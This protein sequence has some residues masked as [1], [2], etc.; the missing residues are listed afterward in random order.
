MQLYRYSYSVQS[1]TTKNDVETT[2][3]RARAFGHFHT[4]WEALLCKL[5][6]VIIAYSKR[7][8]RKER[9]KKTEVEER[10]IKLDKLVS[11]GKAKTADLQKLKLLND[12][13]IEAR[14]EKLKGA[15][16]RSRA[17]WLELGEKPSKYFLNLENR[18]RINK[19]IN[20]IKTDDNKIIQ[21]GPDGYTPEFYQKNWPELGHYFLSYVN[22]SKYRGY[23]T[24]SFLDGVI[25]CLPKTG[26]SRN[27]IKNWRPISLL[28]T[29]YKLFSTCITNRLRPL[30]ENIV[31]SE[32]KGFLEN[33]SINDCTRLMFDVINGCNEKEIDGLILLVDFEKA[34]D[35]IS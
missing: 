5:R 17:E 35:S 24:P 28:N 33:R 19:M 9:V 29:S 22:E 2:N 10:I 27:L 30:L 26:K 20:K 31:S 1:T 3:R 15:L 32:Q 4:F 16:I 11:T 14:Q 7:K 12:Q 18:N 23:F 6:G 13:L 25:T 34:F 21:T 8:N